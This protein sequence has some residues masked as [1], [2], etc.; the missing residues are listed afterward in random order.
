LGRSIALRAREILGEKIE[1]P[2][3]GYQGE[4]IKDIA[5]HFMD[6]HKV[7]DLQD[8]DKLEASVFSQY[9]VDYLMDIIRKELTDFNVCFDVWSH[10]SRIAT[11]KSI[12]DVLGFLQKKGFLYEKEGALWFQSTKLGDDKD[13]VVRKS[14]GSYTYLTPDIAYHKDKFDRG[15]QKVI[16]IWGPD[17]HGYIPR[18]TASVQALGQDASALEVLIVQL[19]TLYRDGKPLS[20]STRKG[21]YISLR[22]VIDEVGVDAARFFFLMRHIKAH[23]EFDLELAKKETSEN[24][25]YYVQYAH[26]RINSILKK[27]EESSLVASKAAW[28]ELKE[29][30][31]LDLI[32]RIAFFPNVLLT[33][34]GVRDPFAL[35]SYM[36][37]LATAFHRFYDRHQII[38]S[39]SSLAAARLGLIL[40]AKTVLANGLKLLGVTA[41][42][43]M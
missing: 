24:P 3:E 34:A 20:M 36:Q 32:R 42:E 17:H 25:V 13:R 18:L 10:Q 2:E 16:N 23:L 28:E 7:K 37:E 19:A 27:A 4:Y 8:L 31:E 29:A 33:C 9:G 26:A 1:F 6:E 43:K 40:A 12:D 11:Q 41:P 38:G 15:F 35:G 5:R 22:E 39:G 21:Q 14:D 30:E